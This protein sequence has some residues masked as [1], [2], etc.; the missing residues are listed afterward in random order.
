MPPDR[1]TLVIKYGGTTLSSA[2]RICSVSKYLTTISQQ[3][4][5]V[6]VCSAVGCTTDDLLSISDMI[7]A[8]DA[9]GVSA[10]MQKVTERHYSIS[11]ELI[12]DRSILEGLLG[13]LDAL[14]GE[15]RSLLDVLLLLGQETPLSRDYLLSF[16]ERFSVTLMVAALKDR[17][18]D[19]VGLSGKDVGIITDSRFGESRPLIDTTRLRV[20]KTL[21]SLIEGRSIP[22]LGG[23]SGADQ[24]GCLT[25]FG[26]GGSDYT[27]TIIGSC[28]G[29]DQIWLMG[30]V[31][32]MMT[33]SPDI[34]SDSRVLGEISYAEA[35][36]MSMFGS[37]QLHS[38]TFEP[39]L[40]NDAHIRI[41]SS[42]N[43]S[44]EGTLV[45]PSHRVKN[46]VKCVSMMRGNGIIDIRG[47]GMVG[48]PG[49]AAGIF[50]TLADK[51]ISVMMI[52]QNPS[53]SS[54]TIVLKEADLYRAADALENE[55][56][57][58]TIARLN[59]MPGVAIVALIGEGLRG[60]VGTA[61]RVFAAVSSQG[62]NIMMI[63][64][65][66]SELNLAFVVQDADAEVA[67]RILHKEFGL[68]E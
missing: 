21:G 19:V 34:V 48:A 7:R 15:L 46:T 45:V 58:K 33:A 68:A 50:S 29:A 25:T 2:S 3:Y 10:I 57:G 67:V 44:N 20:S 36:E 5:M 23:C 6:V 11:R 47:F 66:S 32:G 62:I 13:S 27:A 43:T 8:G 12:D 22:V 4:D 14:F 42:T 40:D 9:S 60:T 16:G 26:R 30:E 52:T 56:H 65:G 1:P 17:R 51:G 59:V 31:D 18:V 55:H 38:R 54:I 28:I 64:Q 53:E 49:T 61:S 41:R 24:H 37:K 35:V 39:V 63:T